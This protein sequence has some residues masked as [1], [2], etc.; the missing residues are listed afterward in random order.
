MAGKARYWLPHKIGPIGLEFLV[1]RY[2][3]ILLPR[4]PL[5][6]IGLQRV[7]R[8][9]L[10]HELIISQLRPAGNGKRILLLPL[11]NILR[12]VFCL[13]LEIII[14][15]QLIYPIMLFAIRLNGNFVI[16]TTALSRIG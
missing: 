5:R 7:L 9:L 8:L 1:L 2:I 15:I 11:M 12:N 6:L 4:L 16:S 3:F 14:R 13:L 10:L